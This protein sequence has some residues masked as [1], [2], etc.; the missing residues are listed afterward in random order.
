MKW[1]PTFLYILILIDGRGDGTSQSF[2]D[3]WLGSQL[4]QGLQSLRVVGLLLATLQNNI[5]E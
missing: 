1:Q 4:L 2:V 5:F 3:V